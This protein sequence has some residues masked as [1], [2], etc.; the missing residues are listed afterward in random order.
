MMMLRSP[1]EEN[2]VL[3]KDQLPH[4]QGET[5]TT[6]REK[7]CQGQTQNPSCLHEGTAWAGAGRARWG[8]EQGL[9]CIPLCSKG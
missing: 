9:A 2:S 1:Q 8:W 3:N 6:S 7:Q 5:Q 4:G